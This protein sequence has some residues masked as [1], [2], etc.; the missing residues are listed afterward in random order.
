MNKKLSDLAPPIVDLIWSSDCPNVDACKTVVRR[1][2]ERA[3]CG[4]L[5]WREWH[6]GQRDMPDYA[7]GYGS[8]TVIVNGRDVV[9]D[10][11][12]NFSDCCRVYSTNSEIRGVPLVEEVLAA[13]LASVDS[14]ALSIGPNSN[15]ACT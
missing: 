2:I 12:S 15:R 1:A 14:T 4:V 6:V 3:D 7:K 13:I 8:P 11:P 9:G 10:A 5:G